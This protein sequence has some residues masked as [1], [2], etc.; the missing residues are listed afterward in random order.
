MT[1]CGFLKNLVA[2][3]TIWYLQLVARIQTCLNSQQ[4]AGTCPV[5]LWLSLR[6]SELFKGHP[7]EI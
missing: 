7:A 6:I 3:T 2:A 1:S 4:V 5:K